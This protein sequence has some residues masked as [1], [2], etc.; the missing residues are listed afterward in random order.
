MLP[1][2]QFPTVVTND[3]LLQLCGGVE[4]TASKGPIA[5]VYVNGLARSITFRVDRHG[6]QAT[7]SVA[8]A[9]ITALQSCLRNDVMYVHTRLSEISR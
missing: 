2:C 4:G 7:V 3:E 9:P 8:H 5:G 6:K 1:R